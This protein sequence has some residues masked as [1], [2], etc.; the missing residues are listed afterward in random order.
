MFAQKCLY[1]SMAMIYGKALS[2]ACKNVVNIMCM[3]STVIRPVGI[4]LLSC[5]IVVNLPFFL[6]FSIFS[7]IVCMSTAR[8][9][10]FC[11]A[12]WALGSFF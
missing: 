11:S 7:C 3:H 8:S 1:A 9:T 6:C 5:S 12:V 2:I 10:S 4:F